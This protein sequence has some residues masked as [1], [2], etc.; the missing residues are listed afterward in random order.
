M[1]LSFLED[2]DNTGASAISEL[3]I[4]YWI[5]NEITKSFIMNHENWNKGPTGIETYLNELSFE[6][7]KLL[8]KLSSKR[9][10]SIRRII[11]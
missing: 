3:T 11:S 7:N 2:L 5:G 4:C 9:T 8:G 10:L 1:N 6:A